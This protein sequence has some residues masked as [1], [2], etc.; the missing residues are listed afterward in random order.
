MLIGKLSTIYWSMYLILF[1][2]IST[3]T[4]L[5]VPHIW[6]HAYPTWWFSPISCPTRTFLFLNFYSHTH[7]H[8][9]V[10]WWCFS[11]HQ[12][13]HWL[14]AVILFSLLSVLIVAVISLLPT[15]YFASLLQ[16]TLIFL[17]IF[18]VST[19]TPPSPTIYAIPCISVHL[20]CTKT[21]SLME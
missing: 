17:H 4:V 6:F 20:L 1:Y 14:S 12:N 9:F 5:I 10:C 11:S 16:L 15:S 3:A 19:P 8:L 21:C 18:Y 13:N 7:L 2:H